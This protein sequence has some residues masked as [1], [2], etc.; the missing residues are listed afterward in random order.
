MDRL[1]T[2]LSFVSFGVIGGIMFVGIVQGKGLLEMFTIGVSLA[3]AAIPEGLPIVVTVTLALGVF[4]MARRKAICKKLPSVETLGSVNVICADKTGTL[5]MNCM[6]VQYLYTVP[7]GLCSVVD[8]KSI[9]ERVRGCKNYVQLLR[10]GNLC[11]NA[12]QDADGRFIGQSTDI[13]MLKVAVHIRGVDDR[14]ELKRVGEVPF[15][16]DRKL[17][18]V[19]YGDEAEASTLGDG[20]GGVVYVKGALEAVLAQCRFYHVSNSTGTGARHHPLLDEQTVAE[21]N[22]HADQLANRGLRVVAAA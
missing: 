12:Q 13:A 20:L 4:K 10:V 9:S 3:V 5:T 21:I 16:S 19:E 8:E 17:M 6:E 7:D 22:S 18:R 11:N 2:Q 14:G 1:G 15:S